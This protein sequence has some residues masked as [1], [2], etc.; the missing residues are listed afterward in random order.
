MATLH[1][2]YANARFTA[3]HHTGDYFSGLFKQGYAY[4]KYN[5]GLYGKFWPRITEIMLKYIFLLLVLCVG[6]GTIS[7]Q[8]IIFSDPGKTYGNTDSMTIDIYGPIDVSSCSSISFSMDFNFS[9]PWQGSGNMESSDE[10]FSGC[11]GMPQSQNSGCFNCWDFLYVKLVLD[12]DTIFTELIGEAGTMDIEQSGTIFFDTCLTIESTLQIEV[13]TQTWGFNPIEEITFSNIQVLCWN[14]Q[15]VLSASPNPV[16]EGQDLQ[17]SETSGNFSAWSWSGPNGFNSGLQNPLLQDVQPSDAGDY[18]LTVNDANNCTLMDTVLVQV[19]PFPDLP[20]LGPYCELDGN[21]S[22]P[23]PING[24]SGT[25]SGSGVNNNTFDPG[26]AGSGTHILTFTESTGQC[27]GSISVMVN[28]EIVLTPPGLPSSMCINEPPINLP[29]TISGVNGNWSGTGVNN[30]T[31]TPST[32]GTG[33]FTLTFMPDAGFCADNLNITIEVVEVPT[34]SPTG[35]LDA[36]D[37]GTGID[38]TVLNNTITGGNNNVT[39]IWYEDAGLNNPINNPVSYIPGPTTVYA[40]VSN[41][42]CTSSSVTITINLIPEPISFP[43]PPIDT[44]GNNNGIITLNLTQYESSI[45]GN[46]GYNVDWYTDSG[47]MNPINNP[48]SYTTSS[49]II[50]AVVT[51]SICTS[52]SVAIVINVGNA[53]IG[54][55]TTLSICGSG[56]SVEYDL[57]QAENDV[58][59]GGGV[60]T[61]YEDSDTSVHIP[62][63]TSFITDPPST[64]Y[65]VIIDGCRSEPIPVYL[66]LENTIDLGNLDDLD[67][68]YDD[69]IFLDGPH[70]SGMSYNWSGPNGFTATT[71]DALVTSN[72]RPTDSGIYTLIGRLGNC[73]DTA[74]L[75]VVVYDE[76][77][78]SISID[79][80][81]LCNG[82]SSATITVHYSGGSNPLQYDWSDD[83]YDGRQVLTDLGPGTYEVTITDMVGCLAYANILITEPPAIAFNC[84]LLSG[85]SGPGNSDAVVEADV[86]GG[87]EPYVLTW[88]G[89]ASG[90]R[91]IPTAGV[92]NISNLPE[93]TIN[94]IITDTNGCT[95][96]CTTII[97]MADCNISME[98]IQGDTIRCAGDSSVSI[99]VNVSGATPPIEYDWN[100]DN[101]DGQDSLNNLPAENYSVTITDDDNCAITGSIT[102][103]EPSILNTICTVVQNE[104]SAGQLDGIASVNIS[105]GSVPY[106]E[107][108]WS[109]PLSG[110]IM[111]PITGDNEIISLAAGLYYVSATDDNACISECAFQVQVDSTDC[112]I[113][114]NITQE[115]SILCY[116]DSTAGINLTINTGTPPYTIT[117]S[118]TSL[119]GLT[120]PMNLGAGTYSVTVVD[121]QACM[122]DTF[123]VIPGV[124]P[125]NMSCTVVEPPETHTTENGIVVITYSGGNPPIT[126]NYSGPTSGVVDSISSPYSLTNLDAG[127]YTF[128]LIDAHG[129]ETTCSS[130]L[131][132]LGCELSLDLRQDSLIHCYGD[133]TASISS[134]VSNANGIVRFDWNVDILDGDPN[135][136]DLPAGTYILTI[137]DS[138]GCIAIDTLIIT[139]PSLLTLNCRA[140]NTST[141]EI[142]IQGGTPPYSYILSGPISQTATFNVPGTYPINFLSSGNYDITIIDANG[143]MAT[144]S[145]TIP[146][147]TCTIDVD[148]IVSHLSCYGADD[149]SISLNITGAHGNVTIDWNDPSYDG[150]ASISNLTPGVYTVIV[151]DTAACSDTLMIPIYEP[152]SAVVNIIGS[153]VLCEGA[154][155]SLSAIDTFNT[156]YWNGQAGGNTFIVTDSGTV[157]L[158]AININGC[159]AYDTVHIG[160]ADT[161]LV[162]IRDTLCAEDMISVNG[163]IYDINNPSGVEIIPGG[164]GS[165]CDSTIIV[166][167]QFIGEIHIDVIEPNCS[168]VMQTQIKILDSDNPALP[169]DIYYDGVFYETVN[170]IPTTISVPGDG[171]Y[172]LEIVDAHGCTF[173][174]NVTI[175]SRQ[176]TNVEIHG[177][178]VVLKGD[179]VFLSA[180]ITGAYSEVHWLPPGLV[181]CDTCLNTFTVIEGN[182]SVILQV[183]D[184][185]GCVVEV[186]KAI[187]VTEGLDVYIPNIFSPNLNGVNDIFKPF[188]GREVEGLLIFEV[189]DRWGN[190]VYQEYY[191]E[192]TRNIRGWNGKYKDRLLNPAVFVYRIV[193]EIR[194]GRLKNFTGTITIIR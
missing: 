28:Q 173:S 74:S 13:Y 166:D 26:V 140:L 2:I 16:C 11:N 9:M 163:T 15:P 39:V 129:C 119:N 134:I 153:D 84:S 179:T 105:G 167:L 120:N 76:T 146:E 131:N 68:C 52:D 4:F 86:S 83:S 7:A 154:S 168:G 55:S 178:T 137:T 103:T 94:F 113:E 132:P 169:Y 114:I 98:L 27:S 171:S 135:P 187:I 50:Y 155:L 174:Q 142:E 58:Y 128:I 65:V 110:S 165:G 25:W 34:A 150:M 73:S 71:E 20:S 107:L 47:L 111:N 19:I 124:T 175:T 106:M 80:L 43:I 180:E 118:D 89:A 147:F 45:N 188:L 36:C 6:Y 148:S 1:T 62:D 60:F 136:T 78:A 79:N 161:S 130:T 143:C 181:D 90:M 59:N 102:I 104:S 18:I 85:V 21:I 133:S 22:L 139:Q 88:S 91:N 127:T 177:D 151:T 48:S 49:T 12:G 75:I 10:C 152:D 192:A 61:W 37:D 3:P 122:V 87:T 189:F 112:T 40:V 157:T 109:G 108:A 8:S 57:T 121:A 33:T 97:P 170:S 194:P 92:Y 82:D 138:G 30:N 115:D 149:G 159:S 193:I 125:F 160:L 141:A 156:Y 5:I 184:S 17:L 72:A 54:S 101:Y 162:Y 77:S 100:N 24:T 93:G 42:T 51:N 32:A 64:V 190:R 176:G 35:P 67:I 29:T 95:A 99:T 185:F 182:T 183:V 46:S 69:I 117:W 186:R 81:I 31:F 172:L 53:P 123:V 66:E 14:N 56:N 126:L 164:S 63:P 116:G 144:C 70:V 41:G 191:Q 38:L 145:F 158:E 23:N 44:C 96:E